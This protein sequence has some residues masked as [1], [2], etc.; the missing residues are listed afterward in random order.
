MLINKYLTFIKYL[1]VAG[2]SFLLDISLF[3][4]FNHFLNSI[5][6]STILARIISSFINYLL[7]KD[8]VFKS[9]EKN[10]I[11]KY[12]LLVLVQMLVS[13]TIVEDLCNLVVIN[14]T[15]IKIPTELCLFVINY[16]I[17]KYYIFK[18]SN[19]PNI[20]NNYLKYLFLVFIIMF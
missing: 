1:F 7:N 14:P 19:I 17:Q 6:I 3:T 2:F 12:Y 18:T 20:I 15:I 10:T 13:A 8:K 5:V 4:L 11:F 9:K 16:F